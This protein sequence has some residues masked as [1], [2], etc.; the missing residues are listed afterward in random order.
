MPKGEDITTKYRL[1]ISEFKRNITEANNL[2]KV[3]KSEFN[4]ASAGL[5]DWSKSSDGLNAKLKQ[6]KNNN[7]S[8]NFKITS[9]S[10]SITN[11]TKI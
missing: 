11:C 1:D 8:P 9:L 7:R 6:L 5:D 10:I 2:M 4:K 3:S